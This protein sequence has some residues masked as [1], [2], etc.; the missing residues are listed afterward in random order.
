MKVIKCVGVIRVSFK[1]IMPLSLCYASTLHFILDIVG[2]KRVK[3]VNFRKKSSFLQRL[4]FLKIKLIYEK[5]RKWPF[6][7]FLLLNNL[8]K[9]NSK[10]KTNNFLTMKLNFPSHSK[11]FFSFSHSLIPPS[12]FLCHSFELIGV[13]ECVTK[14]TA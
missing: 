5:T 12:H 1:L 7:N 4:K 13:I 9:K 11:F 10:K 6:L 3:L 8:S 14:Y 2:Q